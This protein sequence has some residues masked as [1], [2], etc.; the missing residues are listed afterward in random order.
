[1]KDT[2]VFAKRKERFNISFLLVFNFMFTILILLCSETMV[3]MWIPVFDNLSITQFP[4]SISND[5]ALTQFLYLNLITL[6]SIILM[7]GGGI[8]SPFITY[9]G[10]LPVI[11]LLFGRS[12]MW[13]TG[14]L[15]TM[16]LIGFFIFMM[17]EIDEYRTDTNSYK[18]AFYSGEISSIIIATIISIITK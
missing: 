15:S 6:T 1:M 3:A 5:A 14:Y 4:L 7:S 8:K 12:G 2:T 16:A 11:A 17:P 18:L 10:L 13:M 9:F